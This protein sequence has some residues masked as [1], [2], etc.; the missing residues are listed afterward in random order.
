[1]VLVAGDLHN[2]VF[3]PPT[4]AELLDPTT[5]SWSALEGDYPAD[6]TAT[7]LPSG[8][9]LF[10]GGIDRVWIWVYYRDTATVYEPTTNTWTTVTPMHCSRVDH[11]ATL[12]S[13]GEV[14]VVGGF[15]C[16]GTAERY[17]PASDTWSPAGNTLAR[18]GHAAVL[19]P[20]GEVLVAGGWV[21]TPYGPT[22]TVEVY[23]PDTNTWSTEAS[24]S[25]ARD[26]PTATL[27][28]S[29][30]VLVAGG[31]LLETAFEELYDPDTGTWSRAG[32]LNT[33]RTDHAAVLLPSGKVLVVG[34]SDGEG[35]L[36][37]VE[38][39]DP[40]L[41]TWSRAPSMMKPRDEPSATLLPSGRVLVVGVSDP[42][43]LARSAELYAPDP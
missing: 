42:S 22:E 6:H 16:D 29:G 23:D 37:N 9:V 7:P 1:M 28:P 10:T 35:P 26:H 8:K 31:S 14:L 43:T 25:V 17:D 36:S 27:L 38:L 39:Y 21:E 34:G 12:L 18:N 20:S 19:L 15:P 32:S 11:T 13:S 30:K 41:N 4:G 33:R 5:T 2:P 3:Q 40:I 24:M